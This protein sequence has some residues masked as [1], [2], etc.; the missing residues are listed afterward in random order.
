MS[1]QIRVVWSGYDLAGEAADYSVVDYFVTPRSRAD[2]MNRALKR[3][4]RFRDEGR[5][6]YRWP[7]ARTLSAQDLQEFLDDRERRHEAI[8]RSLCVHEPALCSK[9]AE[10]HADRVSGF[11]EPNSEVLPPKPGAHPAPH[12]SL[13]T[14][15]D[16]AA[17]GGGPD[18]LC[19]DPQV[20]RRAFE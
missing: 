18:A 8:F 14:H 7:L 13:K 2:A 10:A 9:P 11:A 19:R 1:R 5:S 4:E 15:P 17:R 3:A 20:I 6:M 16:R 12:S